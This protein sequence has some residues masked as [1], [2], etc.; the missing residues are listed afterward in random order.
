MSISTKTKDIHHSSLHIHPQYQKL[1]L[2]EEV[3]SGFIPVWISSKIWVRQATMLCVLVNFYKVRCKFLPASTW[4]EM[5]SAWNM[6]QVEN[7]PSQTFL[8]K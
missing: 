2:E 3:K 7:I 1:P 4:S 6:Q 8:Y 5:D